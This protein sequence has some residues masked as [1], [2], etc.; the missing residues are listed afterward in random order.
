MEIVSNLHYEVTAINVK[1]GDRVTKGQV[2]A[3]LDTDAMADEIG[4]AQDALALAPQQQI[5]QN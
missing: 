3:V 2:L 5:P 4:S 1:E